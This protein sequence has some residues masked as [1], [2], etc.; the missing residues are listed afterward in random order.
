MHLSDIN[1]VRELFWQ[2]NIFVR[3]SGICTG[4]ANAHSTMS[5]VGRLPGFF[6]N[7]VK[8]DYSVLQSRFVCMHLITRKRKVEVNDLVK[9]KQLLKSCKTTCQ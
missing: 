1:Q 5:E 7:P 8:P 2:I 4:V 6:P 9:S 3:V